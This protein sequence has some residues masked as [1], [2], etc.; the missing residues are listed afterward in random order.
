MSSKAVLFM[1]GTE[2]WDG[3][4]RG[5]KVGFELWKQNP[6]ALISSHKLYTGSPTS[7][8]TEAVDDNLELDNLWIPFCQQGDSDGMPKDTT[9]LYHQYQ[10]IVDLAGIFVH[11]DFLCLLSYPP[12]STML[13]KTI[14]P[15]IHIT[16]HKTMVSLRTVLAITL[17]QLS[18][19]PP[20][21]FPPNINRPQNDT[22][23]HPHEN[24]Y[25]LAPKKETYLYFRRIS[26]NKHIQASVLVSMLGYFGKAL[27]TKAGAAIVPYWC[28]SDGKNVGD[29]FYLEDIPWIDQEGEARYSKCLKRE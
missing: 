11:S 15:L 10:D 12:L 28:N 24:W 7:V 8:C 4:N 27:S 3:N 2:L 20:L 16:E 17:L 1:D 23:F 26:E 14:G 22:N 19:V 29:T 5:L 13:S 18:A 21:L 6:Y 9:S 25:Y